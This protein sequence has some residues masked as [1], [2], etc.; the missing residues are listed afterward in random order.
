MRDRA[1]LPPANRTREEIALIEVGHTDVSPSVARRLAGFF[2][3]SITAVLLLEVGAGWSARESIETAWSHL[4]QIP[5]QMAASVRADT[6]IGSTGAW[7]KTVAANRAAL[8]GLASFERALEDQSVLGRILRPPAQRILTGWFGAGNEQVYAGRE[9]WLFYRPDV[10]YLTGP[11][12]L[13]RSTLERRLSQASEWTAPPHPD[14]RPAILRLHQQLAE[15][16]ISLIVM[17]TTVKPSIHPEKLAR[18]Y[19]DSREPLHNASYSAFVEQLRRAGVMVFD[20]GGILSEARQSGEQYLAT[21]THWRPE[22]VELVV[23]RL[24]AFIEERVALPTTAAPD[25]RIEE[26]EVVSTGDITV[27]LD[28]PA[29]QALF[30]RE[31]VW[32]RRVLEADGAAWRATRGA[33]VLVLGDSFSNIYSLASMGWGDAA[34]LVEQLS[35][36]LRRPVDRLIQ[37]DDGAFAT[38]VMLARADPE[39]LA[40]TRVVIWQFAARELAFGDWKPIDL[41][42]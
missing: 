15:R 14:P 13:D 25:Y 27:M 21:D 7:N 36:T 22:A 39:R 29:A 34:G 10:D 3:A 33:T 17:P 42:D 40:G 4:T 5:A 11:G 8:S 6:A 23:E 18:A 31:R 1:S 37:N 9:G 12:F 19:R 26:R 20:V 28:L 2:L 30:P 35:Y 24:A 32:V 38:R 16:G 41:P